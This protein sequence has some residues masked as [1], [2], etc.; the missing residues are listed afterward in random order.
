MPKVS[1]AR[2]EQKASNVGGSWGR[3]KRVAAPLVRRRLGKQEKARVHRQL[4]GLG[5]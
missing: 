5:G 3:P 2:K 1:A 4:K